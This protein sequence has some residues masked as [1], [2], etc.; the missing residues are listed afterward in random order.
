MDA[1]RVRAMTM[2][3]AAGTVTLGFAVAAFAGP[4]IRAVNPAQ[5]AAR[6]SMLRSTAMLRSTPVARATAP[7]STT[8][9]SASQKTTPTNQK[10]TTATHT[11]GQPMQSCGSAT[12][13]NTPGHAASAPGSA[14]NP[15]GNAGSHYAGTQPQNSKNPTSVA[16]YDVACF[17]QT[18]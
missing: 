12:A 7:Q 6:M 3:A 2:A 13:P 9:A 16:Q 5:N 8:A 18:K 14:F 10:A 11:T 4:P 1:S 17:N 15:S